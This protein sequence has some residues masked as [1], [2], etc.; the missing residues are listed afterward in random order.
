MAIPDPG[1]MWAQWKWRM[2]TAECA[3]MK[4]VEHKHTMPTPDTE[5]ILSELAAAADGLLVLSEHDYPLLPYRWNGSWPPVPAD[6]AV[7]F[8]HDSAAPVQA[9]PI[10]DFFAAQ[11]AT[12]DWQDDADRERAARFA[13]LGALV[14]ACLNDPVL[15]R[16]GSIAITVLILGRVGATAIGLYTTVIET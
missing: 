12:Y 10:T 6:L 8:A 2:A 1:I 4:L 5:R 9:G 16:I 14:A 11:A 3:L 15:Y 13:A 7:A